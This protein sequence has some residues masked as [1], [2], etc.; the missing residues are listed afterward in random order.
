MTDTDPLA[1]LLHNLVIECWPESTGDGG[2]APAYHRDTAIALSD[3]GVTIQPTAPAEGLD[4][5]RLEA[6]I[7]NAAPPAIAIAL[8]SADIAA[9]AREYDR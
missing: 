4:V 3:A 5:E 1:A 8:N 2:C 9:I 6:A 7:W